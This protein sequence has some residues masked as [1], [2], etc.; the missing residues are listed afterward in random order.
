MWFRI[1]LLVGAMFIAQQTVA[2]T[3]GFR[4]VQATSVHPA[5][6]P[7]L[8]DAAGD[9]HTSPPRHQLEAFYG[10]VFERDRL[11]PEGTGAPIRS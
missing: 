11:A 3:P 4:H 2:A 7:A 10:A 8:V 1:A 6:V 5:L 9:L